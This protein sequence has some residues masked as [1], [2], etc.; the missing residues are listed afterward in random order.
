MDEAGRVMTP[1]SAIAMF[2]RSNAWLKERRLNGPPTCGC[3]AC[4]LCAYNALLQQTTR[5]TALKERL[6]A[7][8]DDDDEAIVTLRDELRALLEPR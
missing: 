4:W 2:A 7:I 8:P 3:G 1:E 6:L 5:V